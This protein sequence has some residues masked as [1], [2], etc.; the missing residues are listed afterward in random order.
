MKTGQGLILGVNELEE[1][2]EIIEID[3][4]NKEISEITKKEIKK[5]N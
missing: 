5:Y 2:E 3:L 4:T 1:I